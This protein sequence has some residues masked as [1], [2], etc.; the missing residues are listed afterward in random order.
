MPL[1]LRPGQQLL[2]KLA[3]Y[4]EKA[5]KNYYHYC[6]LVR[7]NF[8]SVF[9]NML[10]YLSFLKQLQFLAEQSPNQPFIASLLLSAFFYG[11]VTAGCF[12]GYTFIS[13]HTQHISS[14]RLAWFF[15]L[16]F[17]G[18]PTDFLPLYFMHY[19]RVAITFFSVGLYQSVFS[20]YYYGKTRFAYFYLLCIT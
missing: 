11:D 9:N 5:K 18:I 1:R 12:F 4:S 16:V 10:S 3:S 6:L 17:H 14:P 8:F 13:H 2:I 19:S 20:S 7:P 15:L